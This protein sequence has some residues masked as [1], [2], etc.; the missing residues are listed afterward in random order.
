VWAVVGGAIGT[1]GEHAVVEE[2]RAAAQQLLDGHADRARQ[3]GIDV[4]TR[5][6]AT[7][8]HNSSRCPLAAARSIAQSTARVATGAPVTPTM[9]VT[10]DKWTASALPPRV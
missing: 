7:T 4:S 5:V 10:M 3:R 9:I 8:A 6:D 1:V 2:A